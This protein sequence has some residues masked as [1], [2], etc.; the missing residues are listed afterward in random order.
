MKAENH[1]FIL[2]KEL[3]HLDYAMK[4]FAITSEGEKSH[5]ISYVHAKNDL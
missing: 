5:D 3:A 1:S 4:R 2:Q